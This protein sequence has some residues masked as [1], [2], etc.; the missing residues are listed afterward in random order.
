MCSTAFPLAGVGSE[1][2]QT[3]I[4]DSRGLPRSSPSRHSHTAAVT[5][6]R[7]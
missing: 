5:H 2:D 6:M 3:E 7:G 4:R 1:A